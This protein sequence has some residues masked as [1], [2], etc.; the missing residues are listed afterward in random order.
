MAVVPESQFR[1]CRLWKAAR[2]CIMLLVPL[3]NE[4]VEN[5]QT[6][7]KEQSRKC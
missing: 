2:D 5:L 1:A 7:V 3:P 4:A 6:S